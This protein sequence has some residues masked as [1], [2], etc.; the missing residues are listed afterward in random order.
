MK[1]LILALG[2][3]FSTLS[4]TQEQPW[5]DTVLQPVAHVSATF[6]HFSRL[7]THHRKHY[8]GNGLLL[9]GGLFFCPFSRYQL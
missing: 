4:A 9:D 5:I 6:Q 7:T 1:W 3:A 2:V 8:P